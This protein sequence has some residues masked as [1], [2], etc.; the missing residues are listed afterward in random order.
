LGDGKR[1][2]EKVR[3]SQLEDAG[4]KNVLGKAGRREKKLQLKGGDSRKN[5]GDQAI[6]HVSGVGGDKSGKNRKK[7]AEKRLTKCKK[8]IPGGK[9]KRHLCRENT[10][11]ILST[12]IVV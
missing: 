5:T 4:E 3:K 10:E 6:C 7:K 8:E 1:V 2:K 11:R 12:W 9:K